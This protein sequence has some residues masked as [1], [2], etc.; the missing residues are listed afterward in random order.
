M[1]APVPADAG[2]MLGVPGI[3]T[4][5]EAAQARL[6]SAW[7]TREKIK[8][9]LWALTEKTLFRLSFHNWY[10]FRARLLNAFGAKVARSARVRRTVH[11]EIPWHLTIGEH[12]VVGD[13][14][15]LY[16]LGN[17][18]IGDNTTISQGAHLCGGSHD[19][20][21]AEFPLIK[22]DVTVGSQCWVAAE[23]F[24]GPNVTVGDGAVLGARAAA[25]KDLEPWTIYGGNPARPL[26]YRE[27]KG[28]K[29]PTKP[30]PEKKSQKDDASLKLAS[31]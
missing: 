25:F 15:T 3:G 2:E 10:G 29:T 31:A 11:V 6:T 21:V 8:R 27:F 24:V 7:T 1:G 23:A 16:C 17:V 19:C 30:K 14:A 18:S 9:V 4:P 28:N 5:E 12:V 20:S 22:A 26:R 13:H